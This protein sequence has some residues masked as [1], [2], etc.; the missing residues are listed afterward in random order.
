MVKKKKSVKSKNNF[1]WWVLL[2]ILFL[3]IGFV[4]GFFVGKAVSSKKNDTL[5]GSPIDNGVIDRR[6]VTSPFGDS[7]SNEETGQVGDFNWW[8]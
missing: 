8:S 4:A 1:N 6:G 7:V 2:L 5:Y 3:I